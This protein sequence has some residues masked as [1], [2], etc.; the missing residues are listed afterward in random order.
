MCRGFARPGGGEL[1]AAGGEDESATSPASA[2]VSIAGVGEDESATP[3]P[4]DMGAGRRRD[5]VTC[6]PLLDRA[7]SSFCCD[8]RLYIMY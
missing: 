7:R 1:A 6:E 3:L 5:I 4:A 8:R 2:P